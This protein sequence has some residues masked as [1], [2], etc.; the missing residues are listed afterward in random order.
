MKQILFIAMNI[1]L[2][3]SAYGSSKNCISTQMEQVD[4]LS[5]SCIQEV[6]MALET[7]MAVTD[8]RS[9]VEKSMNLGKC[10]I[11]TTSS[12]GWQYVE[13]NGE[14]GDRLYTKHYFE[15][16]PAS[17]YDGYQIEGWYYLNYPFNPSPGFQFLSISLNPID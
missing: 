12:E 13:D 4:Q 16:D 2:V 9:T 15:C 5:E 7:S 1:F 11:V 14:V 10:S 17:G 6:N 8:I 3:Q